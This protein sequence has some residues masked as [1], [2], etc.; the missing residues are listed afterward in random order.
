MKQIFTLM[1]LFI[2]VITN[3]QKKV[4]PVNQSSFTGISLPVGS[5]QDSRFLIELTAKNLFE[6][7]TKKA[8]T[9]VSKVEVLAL[10]VASG[11]SSDSLVTQLSNLGYVIQPI[12]T[13]NKYAWLQKDN[14]Y[15]V[16]YFEKRKTSIDI[17]FGELGAPPASFQTTLPQQQQQTLPEQQTTNEQQGTIQQTSPEQQQIIQQTTA[18]NTGY[19]FNTTNFDD[20]WT[21]TVQ[22]DWVEVIK[23]NIKVLLHF[24]KEGT[25][26]PADPDKLTTAAWNILV[27]PRYSQLVNYKTAYVETN[28]RPYFGMGTVT[29]N[30]SGNSFFVVLF[31]K[32]A[33]WMEVIYGDAVF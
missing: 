33:G 27:A 18:V 21:S 22:E 3:A 14:R 19:A 24:P 4:T 1:T 17:Y 9:T 25:I 29:E 12:E 30:N 16:L 2:S 31:R 15:L 5:K 26:F 11:F 6:M 7:E 28:N 13:D 20:G 10:P 23:G 8:G 32:G